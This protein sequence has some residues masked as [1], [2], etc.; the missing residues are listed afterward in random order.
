M[1]CQARGLV[2][3]GED[4][5]FEALR[6]EAPEQGVLRVLELARLR[7]RVEPLLRVLPEL[8]ELP[9]VFDARV[10]A[11]LAPARTLVT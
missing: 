6:L 4:D 3:K 8:P 9:V 10:M 1:V 5:G 7:R 2:H 11:E